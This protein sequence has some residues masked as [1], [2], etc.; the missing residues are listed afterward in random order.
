MGM[1]KK[2]TDMSRLDTLVGRGTVFEGSLT[3]RESI[4]VEGAVKGKIVCEGTVI[5][6]EKGIF[7]NVGYGG[8]QIQLTCLD[9]FHQD[10]T[11]KGL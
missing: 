8:I 5:I 6:G 1:F 11:G 2:E 3:S 4:C 7:E 10:G 9:E